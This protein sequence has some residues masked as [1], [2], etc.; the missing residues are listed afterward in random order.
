MRGL[1]KHHRSEAAAARPR[2]ARRATRAE[3]LAPFGGIKQRNM[4]ARAYALRQPIPRAGRR[5]GGDLTQEPLGCR[6]AHKTRHQPW[7]TAPPADVQ[8]PRAGGQ[9]GRNERRMSQCR[10]TVKPNPPRIRSGAK[11]RK[12]CEA[13]AN[14]W[15]RGRSGNRNRGTVSP[16]LGDRNRHRI[17]VKPIEFLDQL[18]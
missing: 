15:G 14:L 18:R 17:V 12:R 4:V 7:A 16:A 13:S 6:G 5:V 2:R 10:S 1:V 3:R 9:C 11:A 8:L